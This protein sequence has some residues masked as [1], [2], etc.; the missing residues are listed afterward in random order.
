MFAECTCCSV[1]RPLS[2]RE[3]LDSIPSVSMTRRIIFGPAT[4]LVFRA[5]RNDDVPQRRIGYCVAPVR[6]LRP[7]IRKGTRAVTSRADTRLRICSGIRHIQAWTGKSPGQGH[8][9]G[10]EA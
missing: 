2:T 4:I 6:K 8:P 5:R 1:S 10:N 3:A 9:L 7:H